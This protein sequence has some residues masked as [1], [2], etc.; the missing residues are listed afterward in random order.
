MPASLYGIDGIDSEQM[1]FGTDQ[2]GDRSGKW[3]AMEAAWR[4]SAGEGL[5]GF[6]L[7]RIPGPHSAPNV[8]VRTLYSRAPLI[9]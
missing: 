1:I 5:T 6:S 9:A 4:G 2:D 3:P 7:Q 8:V